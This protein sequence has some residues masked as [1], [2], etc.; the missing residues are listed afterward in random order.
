MLLLGMAILVRAEGEKA[1]GADGDWK[2]FKGAWFEVNYPAGFKAAASLPSRTATRGC[3]SAFFRSPDGRVEFYVFSPQWNG[4][5]RDIEV[6]PDTETT[7]STKLSKA[8]AKRI[9]EVDVR[10]KD[11]SYDRSFVDT[12][13]TEQNTRVVFGIRYADDKSLKTHHAAYR[14]FKESLQQFGD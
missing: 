13:N 6:K 2:T 1:K 7:V 3:D 8:G 5:P 9:R 12:E 11:G 4:D 14:K 10:A